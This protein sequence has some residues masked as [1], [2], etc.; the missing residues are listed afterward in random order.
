MEHSRLEGLDKKDLSPTTI[1]DISSNCMVNMNM[2]T[3]GPQAPL[4]LKKMG[5]GFTEALAPV[6]Y[7]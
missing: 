4:R 7:F 5:K 6:V 1:L 3:S 2:E